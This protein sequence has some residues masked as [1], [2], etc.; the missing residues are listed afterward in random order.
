MEFPEKMVLIGVD[1]AIP[2]LVEMLMREGRLPNIAEVVKKGLFGSVLAPYPTVT[3]NNWTSLVTGA[4]AGTTGITDYHVHHPGEPLG[5]IYSGFNTKECSAEY[6]WDAAER[7]GKN[8]LL[9]KYSA[10]WPP[11]IKRG[12]QVDGCGPNWTDEV[13]EICGESLFTNIRGY[14]LAT[15]IEFKPLDNN[16]DVLVSQLKF[17]PHSQLA[18]KQRIFNIFGKSTLDL[19]SIQPAV[20]YAL[21]PSVDKVYKE[22][23]VSRSTEIEDKVAKLGVGEWSDWIKLSF[24]LK[25]KNIEGLTRFK[26]I[27]LSEDAEKI[28]LYVTHVMPV[29]G[30]TK[31]E[32]VGFELLE[33]FGGFVE[34]PGWDGRVRGWIDDE[35][36]LELIDYQNEWMAEASIY[37]MKKY[38]CDLFFLQTHGPDYAH[39]LYMNKAD[40]LTNP[41]EESRRHNFECLVK[42]YESVDR[43]VGTI[44]KAL[45]EKTL[46]I[47][48]SDHGAQSHVS[49]VNPYKIL[50]DGGFLFFKE[51]ESGRQVI[52]WSNT[53][54]APQRN[55]HIYVNLKGREPHGIVE[56]GEDY[57]KVREKAIELLLNFRDEK[58]SKNPFL[59]VLKREDSRVLGLYGDRIGDI[60]YAVKPGFGH[61]HGQQLSTARFG[62]FGSMDSLV[63]MA[64]PG[65]KKGA[66]MKP[67]RW[68]IDI[69]PTVAHLLGIPAPRDTDGSIIYDILEDPDGRLKERED[70]KREAENWRNAYEKMRSLIHIA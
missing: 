21:L 56:P 6:L 67:T 4:W 44:V 50:A 52:D 16:Q 55:C 28:R 20:L 12:I 25:D 32:T 1:G 49:Y 43:L 23:I 34:R 59:F 9:M 60:I 66:K 47:V 35:T 7:A 31:P 22:I 42:V 62:L 15:Q 19:T 41:D 17:T 11:T 27:E 14:P 63:I 8:V 68:L 64:G 58:T 13:H 57:E 70:L 33:K 37:L 45:D 18:Q 10:S 39:H 53:K 61:E 54:A 3:P 38:G 65:V 36:F 5:I 26:L 30:W 40:P 2:D 69:V 46:V 24:D 51:D 48:V 29:K